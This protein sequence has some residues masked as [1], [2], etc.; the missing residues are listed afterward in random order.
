M[1]LYWALM[2][3]P[4]GTKLM[5]RTW[6]RRDRVG[7]VFR[8]KDLIIS[9]SRLGF[10]SVRSN[11]YSRGFQKVHNNPAESNSIQYCSMSSFE[12]QGSR[13]RFDM[14]CIL[15]QIVETCS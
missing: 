8:A 5:Y 10:Y 11:T 15:R 9:S 14:D 1:A 3:G 6:K 2:G 12:G 13:I 7:F 4:G